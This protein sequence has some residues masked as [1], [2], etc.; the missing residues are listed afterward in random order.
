MENNVLK[1]QEQNQMQ[2]KGTVVS[3][4]IKVIKNRQFRRAFRSGCR[5]ALLSFFLLFFLRRIKSATGSDFPVHDLT[6]EKLEI[7][8]EKTFYELVRSFFNLEIAGKAIGIFSTL[9]LLLALDRQ[10][11]KTE[12]ATLLLTRSREYV[13]LIIR[14]CVFWKEPGTY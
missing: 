1:M 5:G 14:A 2:E 7:K 6:F 10:I 12:Q 8:S 3:K 13:D 9:L 11:Q 4:L